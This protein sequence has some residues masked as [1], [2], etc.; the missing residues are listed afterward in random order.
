MS[1]LEPPMLDLL[2]LAATVAGFALLSLYLRAC[3]RA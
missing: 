3:G 2:M 1:K